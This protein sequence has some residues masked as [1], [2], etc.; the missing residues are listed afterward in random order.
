MEQYWKFTIASL[1]GVALFAF[2]FELFL[3]SIPGLI[4]LFGLTLPEIT[5]IVD[6]SFAVSAIAAFTVG[7]LSDRYGRKLMFM[8]T[9][10]VYSIGSFFTGLSTTVMSFIYSRGFTS[11]GMGP[12]EPL[13]FTLTAETAPPE[14][15]GFQMMI[16]S[17][18]FPIGQAVGSAVVYLFTLESIYLPYV[19]FIGV[20]PALFL[21]YLRKSLPETE[22][23]ED[24]KKA[25]AIISQGKSAST[26]YD[27][28]VAKSLKDPYLQM[29]DTDL[30]RKSILMAIYTLIVAG[31]V[32]VSLIALPLY[33]IYV[34]N[35]TF[36][37][38]LLFEFISF[39]LAALGYVVVAMIGNKIGRRN[40]ILIGLLLTA[41]SLIG[42]IVSTT[43]GQVLVFN[44]LF[45]F[46]LFSQWAA[47]PFY[48]NEMFPTR[49]RATASNFGYAFQW[50]G[51]IILPTAILTLVSVD[52]WG[53]TQAIVAV[54]LIP[55]IF[56]ILVVG[57]L[58]VDH[59]ME[60]LEANA[61]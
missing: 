23:F 1:V 61:I 25:K 35:L 20:L 51:N 50:I 31:S 52:S 28:D 58:P 21:L 18:G 41:V 29:F 8:I 11:I 4:S 2:D 13:G 47:W 40:I 17:L 43:P 60:T 54:V 57:L 37:S 45:I 44:I 12:D 32:A 27:A 55:I 9:I 38:T 48:L 46:F 42:I 30:R 19:F 7:W 24:L 3:V 26:K 56:C 5:L 39:G 59:P 6:I 14:K 22:R 36:V 33:Y 10:L 15:R 34:K 49:V 53:W 16:V